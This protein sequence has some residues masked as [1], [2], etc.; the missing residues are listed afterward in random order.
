MAD[1]F[2]Q[3]KKLESLIGNGKLAGVFSVD[4]GARSVPLEVGYWKTGPNAGVHMRNFTTPGTG[5]HAVQNSLE[6]THEASLEDIA[7]S[8]LTE[9]PRP[10]MKRHLDRM[11]G[12]FEERA[13][14]VTGQY[15]QSTGRFVID[16]GVPI[17]EEYG[18]SYGVGP[19]A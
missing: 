17:S 14:R 2:S 12:A 6:V 5:P 8:T 7:K 1:F 3:T 10:G 13:P 9:G 4:G 19:G 15:S 16:D 11:Q 18:E